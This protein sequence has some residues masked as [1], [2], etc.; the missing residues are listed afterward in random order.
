MKCVNDCTARA[1]ANLI[2]GLVTKLLAVALLIQC[3]ASREVL[4]SG[5]LVGLV[6]CATASVYSNSIKPRG[7]DRVIPQIPKFYTDST[8]IITLHFYG[9]S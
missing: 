8:E 6:V 4:Q 9:R 7:A 3:K 5:E 1:I 2:H